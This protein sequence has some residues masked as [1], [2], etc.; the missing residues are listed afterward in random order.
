[1]G[2]KS[3]I[4]IGAAVFLV[5]ATLQ[6]L[7]NN[8]AMMLAGRFV[9]GCSIGLLS[10]VVSLYQSEI[11]PPSLRGGLT[12]LYQFM[13]TVGILAAVVLDGLVIDKENGWRIAIWLQCIPAILLLM[14]MPIMPRSPR[15][16]V[17]QSRQEDALEVLL[18]I[19][20]SEAEAREEH[21]KIVAGHTAASREPKVRWIELARGRVGELLL[22]G[23]TLQLL[24]QFCGMNAFMYFGPRIFQSLGYNGQKFQMIAA[25][26]N[27]LATVPALFLAD[28]CGRR[29]LLIFSALGM[30][31]ACFSMYFLGNAYRHGHDNIV[32]DYIVQTPYTTRDYIVACILFFIVNFA[33][34][35][36]P[37][38][39]TYCAEMFPLRHRA[40][41]AGVTS[42]ANWIG[43]FA[44]AQLTPILL[45]SIDFGIFLLFG[46]F[47]L[48][49]LA[50]AWWLPETKGVMLEE[51]DALFD[52]KLG[53]P[54]HRVDMQRPYT[55]LAS[56]SGG[57]AEAL[58]A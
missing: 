31:A 52:E 10:A 18:S 39:W 30:A 54:S 37:M 14:A 57:A 47:C 16:L 22:V 28:F 23:V 48:V 9:A 55:C 12:S 45:G 27:V 38:V 41:C 6:A 3:S 25:T 21:G 42:T 11:A 17:M 40:R 13:I 46:F 50:L 36:G 56:S 43:N 7:A 49:A 34:G 58:L 20:A 15:W 5:G 24:Q 32:G 26:W 51:I 35:W 2:R 1:M 29:P 44:V 33:Y 8:I 53:R 4:G 19:R